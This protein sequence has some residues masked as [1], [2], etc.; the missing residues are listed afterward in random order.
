MWAR[1]QNMCQNNRQNQHKQASQLMPR[2]AAKKYETVGGAEN[3]INVINNRYSARWNLLNNPHHQYF[4]L[5]LSAASSNREW[6]NK[7]KE[8]HRINWIN[9]SRES[10]RGKSEL[11]AININF[12]KKKK[13]QKTTAQGSPETPEGSLW[14]V[15][16]LYDK[17]SSFARGKWWK[18]C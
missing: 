1:A 5:P 18:Q 14:L 11:A 6:K 15:G 4:A 8:A 17:W 3:V 2:S 12:Q 9:S 13:Q 7:W 10:V 16:L